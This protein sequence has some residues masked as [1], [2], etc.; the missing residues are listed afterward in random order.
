[1]RVFEEN[2][3]IIGVIHF[4]AAKAVGESVLNP[5][6]YYKNNLMPMINLLGAMV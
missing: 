4:A 3:D 1:M 5:L 2:Q 6:F